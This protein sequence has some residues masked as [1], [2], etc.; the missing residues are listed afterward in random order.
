MFVSSISREVMKAMNAAVLISLL[1]LIGLPWVDMALA[2]WNITKFKC[3]VS[4][5][6]PGYLFSHEDSLK[7]GD[8]WFQ[9]GLQHLLGWLFLGLGCL[10]IPH[11]W[12][13]RSTTAKG[14]RQ[15]LARWWRYGNQRA[16]LALRRK[17]LDKNPVLWLALR[18]RWM[19]RLVW[20]V[21]IVAFGITLWDLYVYWNSSQYNNTGT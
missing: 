20:T 17:F 5:A 12:Q 10:C 3:I 4:I 21:L 6:S 19:N 2:H 13:E 18:D 9:L 16:R 8:F 11:A 14:P 1:F 7:P 15:S